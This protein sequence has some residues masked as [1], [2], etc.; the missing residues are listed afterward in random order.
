VRPAIGE[1]EVGGGRLASDAAIVP[2][3]RTGRRL[4]AAFGR[5]RALLQSAQRK[6]KEF[7]MAVLAPPALERPLTYEDLAAMPDDG[8]L[9][10]LINGELFELIGPTPKHQRASGGLYDRLKP[11]VLRNELGLVYYSPID[12][13][14]TPYTTVQPDIV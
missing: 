14:L 4:R 12:V 3:K 6:D 11:F 9:Y 2:N 1:N 10:E 5:D 7:E 13:Y 8:K